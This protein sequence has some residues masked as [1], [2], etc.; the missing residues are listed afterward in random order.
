MSAPHNARDRL[1]VALDTDLAHAKAA[2]EALGESVT[3]YKIGY[4]L[5]FMGGLDLAERL[6]GAGKKVFLDFK[7]HDIGNTVERGIASLVGIGA[8]FVTVHAYPQTMRA[9]VEGRGDSPLQLLAV[10]ALTSYDDHDA[11][12]AGYAF[13][14]RDL[15]RVRAEQARVI[16]IDGIV[17][18]AAE[19]DLVRHVAGPAMHIVTPG[20]RPAG[21]ARGDQKR[22][23]TP[24]EA[25]H[26]G[27]DYLVVG[28][29]IMEAANPR[30]SAEAIV[31]EIESAL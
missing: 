15:V 12:E 11:A 10:T 25:I 26:A 23:L 29:P 3:F 1:I 18:S 4:E 5:G 30:S 7:L 21:S 31:A 20:I 17:C 22:T 6:V 8:T 28:R 9:A 14:V 13:A 16:G 27:V 24:A 2:V 19:T